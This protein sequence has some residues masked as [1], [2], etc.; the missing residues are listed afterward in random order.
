MNNIFSLVRL[1]MYNLCF[2]DIANESEVKTFLEENH[3]YIKYK[4]N[5][6]RI[7]SDLLNARAVN[8][9][10]CERLDQSPLEEANQYMFLTLQ[11]D[12]SV[13]KLL[14]VAS[15]LESDPT[16][17]CNQ[18]LAS[19]IRQ[20]AGMYSLYVYIGYNVLNIT[21]IYIDEAKE[22][23][24][25]ILLNSSKLYYISLTQDQIYIYPTV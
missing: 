1:W 7:A 12:A 9:G 20:F 22:H 16:H 21:V 8:R 14:K 13:T 15:A 17:D 23:D 25:T 19:R 6:K 4:C 18:E 10:E 24:Y 2:I 5:F 11:K 3:D